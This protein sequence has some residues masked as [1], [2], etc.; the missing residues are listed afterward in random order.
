MERTSGE[1]T[2]RRVVA[3]Y[4]SYADAQAAVD[5]LSDEKFP[6]DR[7]SIVAEDLRFVEQVTGR[8]GYGR[9]ALS[10]LS[11]GAAVGALFGF[12]FGFFSLVEPLVSG[13]ALA[14]YGLIFG[15]IVGLVLGLAS[16][17]AT[18]GQRDFASVGRMQA[19]HYDVVAA[20]EE[21]AGEASR[22]LSRR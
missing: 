7:L 19:G 2:S 5:Y 10:G 18:G 20:D 3:S 4:D 1:Q 11:S 13:L 22:R 16:H 14:L 9:A 17:A 15:A 6:V 12:V 8:V 21:V